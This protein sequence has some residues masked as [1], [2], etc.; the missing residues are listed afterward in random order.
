MLL[1]ETPDNRDQ[2]NFLLSGAL[3]LTKEENYSHLEGLYLLMALVES[4]LFKLDRP[5]AMRLSI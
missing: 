2:L 3:P 1:G 4:R 5:M